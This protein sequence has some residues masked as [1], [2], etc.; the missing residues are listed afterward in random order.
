MLN[1][2]TF[3]EPPELFI[4]ETLHWIWFCTTA[5]QGVSGLWRWTNV[6]LGHVDVLHIG[7]VG[8]LPPHHVR[9]VHIWVTFANIHNLRGENLREEQSCLP[10]ASLPINQRFRNQAPERE[11]CSISPH[12]VRSGWEVLPC[13][14]REIRLP[15]RHHRILSLARASS[16]IVDNGLE[17]YL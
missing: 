5:K 8:F 2:E 1:K 16:D 11:I 13:G 7:D 6:E 10:Q 14:C 3:E 15:G 9:G 12:L 4:I 17:T